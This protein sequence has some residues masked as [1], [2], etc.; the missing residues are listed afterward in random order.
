MD[1]GVEKRGLRERYGFEI[2]EVVLE[3]T[4]K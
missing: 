2:K 4:G 3:N 1:V